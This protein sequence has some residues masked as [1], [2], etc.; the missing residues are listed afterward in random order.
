MFI[1]RLHVSALAG[2]LQA[3]YKIIFGKL[4]HYNGSVVLCFVY[5]LAN[6]AVVY[7]ICGNVKILKC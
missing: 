1:S 4:P 6:T 5:V 7:L 2:H 3:E